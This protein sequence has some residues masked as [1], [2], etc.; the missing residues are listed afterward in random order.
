MFE[1]FMNKLGFFKCKN[2]GRYVHSVEWFG[3]PDAYGA[4]CSHCGFEQL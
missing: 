3:A 1:K 4:V 2:C